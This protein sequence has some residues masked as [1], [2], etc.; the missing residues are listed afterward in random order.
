MRNATFYPMKTN[1]ELT[2][3][4]N[5]SFWNINKDFLISLLFAIA[6]I[7]IFWTG[8]E[9]GILWWKESV[10]GLPDLPT[11]LY[12]LFL[13]AI[14]WIRG[15]FDFQGKNKYL[16]IICIVVDI[17][18]F[19]TLFALIIG[20]DG[21][22]FDDMFEDIGLACFTVFFLTMI[23]FGMKSL[24]KI[25]AVLGI[26]AYVGWQMD[27]ISECMGVMG[28]IGLI[29]LLV[30]LYFQESI[31]LK[32]LKRDL[33][34]IYSKSSNKIVSTMEEAIDEAQRLGNVAASAA[35]GIPINNMRHKDST[36]K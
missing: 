24:A 30:A 10:S 18:I 26:L 6:G 13:F 15:L 2:G 23:L 27:I 11:G 8:G 1:N 7:A 12:G 20:A 28:F 35:T 25:V 17:T 3:K 22:F 21:T 5:N 31:N 19:A 33:I 36:E 32:E 9:T 14:L 34:L 4:T 29:F 16:K